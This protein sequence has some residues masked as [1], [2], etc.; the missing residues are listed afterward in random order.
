MHEV[1]NYLAVA[2]SIIVGLGITTTLDGLSKTIKYRDSHPFYWVH[3]LWVFG[4]LLLLLQ[5]WFGTW[6]YEKVTGWTYARYIL[7]LLAPVALYLLSD[8]M[9]PVFNEDKPQSL[10]AYYYSHRG[11]IFGLAI[12]YFILDGISSST[13]LPDK[14]WLAEDNLFRLFGVAIMA[15]AARTTSHR[16]H[17]VIAVIA[18]LALA[19]FVIIFSMSPLPVFGNGG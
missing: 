19:L 18:I 1:F 11:W 15:I 7:F 12:A 5:Y 17:A 8:L 2:S 10:K 4:L 16:V 6:A 3:T 13:V 14:S 9:F